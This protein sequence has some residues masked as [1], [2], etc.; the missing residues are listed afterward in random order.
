MEFVLEKPFGETHEEELE[1]LGDLSGECERPLHHGTAFL[2]I[3]GVLPVNCIRSRIAFT[4][5]DT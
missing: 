3:S 1:V 5:Y 2:W 4:L